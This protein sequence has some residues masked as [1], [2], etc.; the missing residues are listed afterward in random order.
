MSDHRVHVDS[1][2]LRAMPTSFWFGGMYSKIWAPFHSRAPLKKR[3]RGGGMF[4]NVFR[5]TKVPKIFRK[6]HFPRNF[7]NFQRTNPSFFKN[8]AILPCQGPLPA[9][10][11]PLFYFFG[12]CYSLHT[13]QVARPC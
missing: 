12:G 13:P 1:L 7:Q 2:I 4:D 8:F 5:K 11:A 9:S 10:W 6:Q 3:R